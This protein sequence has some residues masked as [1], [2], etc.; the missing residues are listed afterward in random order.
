VL[1][2]AALALPGA[3]EASLDALADAYL[4][5][6]V[7]VAGTLALLLAAERRLGTDLS[8]LLAR[9]RRWQVPA[10][11]LLGAVPGCGGA[12]IAVTQFSRGHLSFGA[13]VATLIATMGDAMFLLL[14]RDPASA[15][16]VTAISSVVAIVTGYALDALHG[17]D[18]LRP[19]NVA[20]AREINNAEAATE[21]DA[22]AGAAGRIERVWLALA[23]PGL[24]LGVAGAF[25]IDID[26]VMPGRPAH[27]LG[28]AGALLALRM[29]VARGDES[30]TRRTCARAACAAR[31]SAPSHAARKL[32]DDTNFVTAWVVFAFVGFEIVQLAAGVDL[33][34]A[35]AGWGALVPLAA[36]VV[37]F[38]PG[39][40]PQIVITSLYLAGS[41]PLSAQ[42]G[43]AI[44]NDG[45][46][47]FPAI[48][49]APKAALAA[50]AYSALPA[51][52][53]AYGWYWLME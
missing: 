32:I 37:G 43:N 42:L 39:C 41:V 8:T 5:V 15:A 2:A 44:S 23:V 50:T 35:L 1:A 38:V 20:V 36:I 12:I 45:D 34:A 40:G 31:A 29:W 18:F 51:F 3:L 25:Q 52:A 27:W 28:I 11:A 14:A 10:G 6:S 7:F 46:A 47:L 22:E 30:M 9:H 21:A 53:V 33:G 26:A 19:R 48:A 49:V 4:A 17:A 13:L 24:V 16:L